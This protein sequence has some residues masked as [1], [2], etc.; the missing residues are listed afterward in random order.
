[1]RD[2]HRAHGPRHDPS[3]Q[4]IAALELLNAA[5]KRLSAA[6]T[7]RSRKSLEFPAYDAGLGEYRR[8]TEQDV[9]TFRGLAVVDASGTT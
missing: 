4:S 7:A 2:R 9:D 8:Q 6:F 3:A 5:T 1:M